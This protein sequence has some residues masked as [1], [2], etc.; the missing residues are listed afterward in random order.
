MHTCSRAQAFVD[1]L[2]KATGTT[3]EN[4]WSD[5][6]AP[7]AAQETDVKHTPETHAAAAA[8]DS[9]SELKDPLHQ[10]RK[11]GIMQGTVVTTKK[12]SADSS[13]S[14][15]RIEQITH[16]GASCTQ[17]HVLAVLP[18]PKPRQLQ[19]SCTQLFSEWKEFKGSVQQKAPEWRVSANPLS[20]TIWAIEEMKGMV[21]AGLRT[22][23]RQHSTE[24]EHIAIYQSPVAVLVA[25]NHSANALNL[26]QATPMI[27]TGREADDKDISLGELLPGVVFSLRRTLEWPSD[28]PNVTSIPWVATFWCVPRLPRESQVTPNMVLAW[29]A[30]KLADPVGKGAKTRPPESNVKEMLLPVLRNCKAL[31]AGDALHTAPLQG[32]EGRPLE[33]DTPGAA[34]A[35]RAKK[36]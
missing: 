3:I 17:V 5:A 24:L 30:V 31:K 23:W 33:A 35:K 1:E 2:Q 29:V 25:G 9:L 16:Q 27:R 20:S 4:P 6:S 13:D 22:L 32:S 36:K 11:L 10:L 28:E 8:P 34:G 19:L 18:E 12:R 7:A 15:Y 21:H 26:V 14:I